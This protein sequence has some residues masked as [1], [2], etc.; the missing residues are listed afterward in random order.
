M[1]LQGGKKLY[2]LG[3]NGD[4]IGLHVFCLRSINVQNHFKLFP[5]RFEP[6]IQTGDFRKFSV[7]QFSDFDYLFQRDARFRSGLILVSEFAFI[8]SAEQMYTLR[9]FQKSLKFAQTY[10]PTGLDPW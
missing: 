5:S 8:L 4:Q 6:G 9:Q 2:Q 10:W 1:S 7:R 3:E